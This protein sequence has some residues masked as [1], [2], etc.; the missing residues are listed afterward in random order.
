MTSCLMSSRKTELPV[1]LTERPDSDCGLEPYLGVG[2]SSS[3]GS[4]PE[5]SDKTDGLG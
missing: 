2:G 1:D 4:G 3:D 5:V